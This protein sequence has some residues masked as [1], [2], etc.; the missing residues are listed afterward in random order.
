MPAE[1][2]PNAARAKLEAGRLALG[3]S[4]KMARTVDVAKMM[5]TSGFDWLFIDLEH[6]AMSIDS[7]AQLCVAALDVGITPI[8]RVPF[9]EYSMATRLLDNGA[10]G[11]VVPH[12]DTGAQAEE[13]VRHVCYPPVGD[14][15]ISS[16]IPQFDYRAVKPS[17]LM[18]TL[19]ATNIIVAMLETEE[20]IANVDAIASVPG[21]D[22]LM[23]GSNDLTISLGVAGDYGSEKLQDACRKMVAA[24][25]RH[26]KYPGIAGLSG[27][28]HWERYVGLG[29]RFVQCGADFGFMM[30]G[31]QQQSS[32]LNGLALAE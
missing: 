13:I 10:L 28:Q 12:V 16:K 4:I 18:D 25:A 27:N 21:I 8:P 14:R 20:S 31:A 3:A 17:E 22:V 26:G 6:G 1:G 32:F 30:A 24:C 29:A 9:G 19:N 5:K 11:I 15:S 23:I 2:F 7:A